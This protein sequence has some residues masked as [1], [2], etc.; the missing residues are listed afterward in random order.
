MTPELEAIYRQLP[1]TCQRSCGEARRALE[2]AKSN[3]TAKSIYGATCLNALVEAAGAIG[4]KGIVDIG[5]RYEVWGCGVT[6]R[7]ASA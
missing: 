6:L 3:N 2:I 4:C 1:E 5:D 7:A